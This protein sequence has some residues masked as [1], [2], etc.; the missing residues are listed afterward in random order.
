MSVLWLPG[1]PLPTRAAPSIIDTP[2]DAFLRERHVHRLGQ[3]ADQYLDEAAEHAIAGNPKRSD[4][5]EQHV[6]PM[7]RALA[8][9]GAAE[10]ILK[11][12]AG[13]TG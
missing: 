4:Y 8:E 11:A 9:R 10:P 3:L 6:V 13:R 5:L 7:V 1:D 2:I 12:L